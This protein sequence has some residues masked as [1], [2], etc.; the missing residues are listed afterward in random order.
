[1]G[2][3][4]TIPALRV[5]RRYGQGGVLKTLQERQK[6]RRLLPEPGHRYQT[7]L[8]ILRR[9]G[10]QG[11]YART[12]VEP[13]PRGQRRTALLLCERRNGRA[14]RLY[15]VH[16]ARQA[17]RHQNP[18]RSAR[19]GGLPERQALFLYPARTTQFLLRDL[20][21]AEPRRTDTRRSA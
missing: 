10:R 6:L 16:I 3:E 1:M 11:H 13:L 19:A 20:S 15:G 21:R 18:W 7:E 2:R 5:F 14:D 17:V 8:S 4:R 12:G 9:K